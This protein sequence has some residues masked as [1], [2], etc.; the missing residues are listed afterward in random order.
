MQF[1]R[2]ERPFGAGT[3][4]LETGKIAKQ[5]HGAVVARYGDTMILAAAERYR[6]K[7]I[8]TFDHKHFRAVKPLDGGV[9]TILPADL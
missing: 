4:S 7:R 3:L 1:S 9:F 5:A 2:V 6:T 8:L